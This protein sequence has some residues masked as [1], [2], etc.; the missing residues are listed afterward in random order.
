[1]GPISLLSESISVT[2]NRLPIMPVLETDTFSP[3]T[4]SSTLTDNDKLDNFPMVVTK[5]PG[6]LMVKE[7]DSKNQFSIGKAEAPLLPTVGKL[8]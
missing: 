3:P 5:R 6:S 2:S 1:M 8:I 4:M 7:K